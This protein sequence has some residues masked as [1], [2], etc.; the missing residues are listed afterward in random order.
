MNKTMIALLATM[1]VTTTQAKD[2]GYDPKADPFADYRAAVARAIET[3]KL[4]LII[5]GGDWCRWCH[6]LDRF[7]ARNADVAQQLNDTF[8]VMKVY[9]GPENYNEL[10]F[11]QLPTAYGAPH[12][13]VISP[14]QEVLVSQSTGKLERGRND[15][16]KVSF[17]AFIDHWRSR[18][19]KAQRHAVLERDVAAHPL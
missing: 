1:L 12:F 7:L 8:I 2:L 5:A 15:Y 18:T 9:V 4:V 19:T 14:E 6:V 3:D 17:L 16:D 11:S 13:W 10:F